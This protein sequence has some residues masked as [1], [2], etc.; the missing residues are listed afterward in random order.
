MTYAS[1]LQRPA[2]FAASSSSPAPALRSPAV[3]CVL[4]PCTTLSLF[5]K[6]WRGLATCSPAWES[7]SLPSS[8]KLA[9][10]TLASHAQGPHGRREEESRDAEE[11]AES[12]EAGD[13]LPGEADRLPGEADRLGHGEREKTHRRTEGAE[14]KPAGLRAAAEKRGK[15]LQDFLVRK[16]DC[17]G[18]E[19]TQSASAPQSSE[20]T[21]QPS[22][23]V[24]QIDVRNLPSSSPPAAEDR[25][26]RLDA[27]EPAASLRVG[28]RRRGAAMAER[29]R[30]VRKRPE[31]DGEAGQR[32]AE[33]TPY[34]LSDE[35]AA[36]AQDAQPVLLRGDSSPASL[37]SNNLSSALSALP[38]RFPVLTALPLFR[39]PAF[40]GFFQLLHIPDNDV[41]EAL[42]RQKKSGVPG[43]DYVAGFL[44]IEEKEKE[45][46]VDEEGPGAKLRKDAGRVLDISELHSTGSLLH[47][48]NFAP[49]SSV[50]GG[51]VVVMPYRRIR[52][53]GTADSP[54]SSP[55]SESQPLSPASTDTA[56]PSSSSSSSRSS[57]SSLSSPSASGVESFGDNDDGFE[58]RDRDNRD[59]PKEA[60]RTSEA[61]ERD[62]LSPASSRSPD[63]PAEGDDQSPTGVS[64]AAEKGT[65]GSQ[66]SSPSAASSTDADPDGQAQRRGEA[67]QP[68]SPSSL[69]PVLSPVAAVPSAPTTFSLLRVRIA[70]LPDESGKFDVNDTQK[71]LHLEIIA[72]MKE[73]L[74][75]SY[76]YKEHFDQVVRFYNLDSPHKLADLVAGMSFAK[77]QELQA[78]LAEEDI[79]KRLRLVLEIAKKDLEFSKLQAQ[80]KAQVEEKMNKMQRK[81]LLTEQLKFLKRELGDVKDDKESILDSFS[82]RLEKKK[83]VMPAEVQ[84][85]VAYEL[86]KLSSLEQSSSEFNITRTYTDC[87]LSL[88]WG[89]YTEECSDIFSAEKVL[90]EDHY[91]L[92]DVKDRILEFIAVTIL[93]KDVQGKI[94]CLVGPPGVG[95]TSVGQSIARALRR[96]FYRI[97]LGGMCDVAELRGHRRTYISALPGKVIQALKECQTM[98]PVILLDEIDKLGRDFRGDPSSALLEILDPSQNKSFR[99]Y[100][101]DIPVDLSKV[102]FVCTANTPDVIPGPLL[103]RMEVIRI[104]GYI[105]Q[106]KLCIARNYLLPQTSQSTGLSED[107][108][109]ISADVLEKL[110]RDYAREA[111]VRSLLKLIEKIYRKAALALVRK[112]QEKIEVHL[113]NLSKFVG[114]PAFQ[115]DRLYAETPPGVVMGLAWTQLGGATL[116]VEAIGRRLR[117]T[118]RS[119]TEKRKGREEDNP[120]RRETGDRGGRRKPRSP[121]GAEGR[122]KVTGQ[123]G[124]VM[125]ESSEI[126]LTFCRMFVRCI[127]PSNSYLETAQIHL[128]VPEGATPKDGPSAGITMATALVSLAL[129]RPVLPDVAMTGELT[130]TGKV[131]KIG[132]VKEKV[133][134][135]RRENVNTLIFPKA[136]EREFDELPEDVREGLSVHFASTYDDVYRVAFGAEPPRRAEND[137]VHGGL[138]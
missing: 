121:A 126:A 123:L 118:S 94:I 33:A 59:E 135:A 20:D 81:F 32:V 22:G 99:D 96:K 25:R 134:A 58:G 114:Q 21:L 62:Q 85:A 83:R 112:E 48:L 105:F 79:E 77:R 31:T 136:N 2:A 24:T 101:L 66:P 41:F 28:R 131:L 38:P 56:A 125:S 39:R 103:D 9:S 26:G 117:E 67:I 113:D 119:A 6:H 87:L 44:T 128:H 55:V 53:L 42:V 14:T 110:V 46:E 11:K 90:N 27:E 60:F 73:L 75:Q 10:R 137:G 115:S 132:G 107:Q 18:E 15:A 63:P 89:E 70:Y 45:H 86:S 78:V 100:Y 17:A 52:L 129:N 16:K 76:F 47:L 68:E 34:R 108:I 97:S 104:A 127:E 7:L 84:K 74:K 71:A 138:A 49:H 120:S 88:P 93:K 116:Y 69:S 65:E 95:K 72:T 35:R 4:T 40:P 102:L 43:G 82:E 61:L 98:N 92:S 91:G 80:V 130:L 8:Q 37:S 13:S 133:I 124:N 106:E 109:H 64:V 111:G 122:L 1:R 23:E 3:R 12:G 50:K 30:E 5:P 19:Q 51:Q 36:E 29:E 57:L 54:S